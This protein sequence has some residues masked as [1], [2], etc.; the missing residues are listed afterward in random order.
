MAL[1]LLYYFSFKNFEYFKN[2]YFDVA[3]HLYFTLT[4]KFLDKNRYLC[5]INELSIARYF[6]IKLDIH[7]GC[8]QKDPFCSISRELIPYETHAEGGVCKDL[9]VT[10]QAE[11]S[12]SP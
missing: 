8:Y 3:G 6:L 1:I 7:R 11:L 2:V 9:V 5:S 12:R 10:H 4:I